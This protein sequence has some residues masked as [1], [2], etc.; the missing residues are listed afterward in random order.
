MDKYRTSRWTYRSYRRTVY[1]HWPNGTYRSK[2]CR[3]LRRNWRNRRIRSNGSYR[4]GHYGRNWGIWRNRRIRPN[5]TYRSNGSSLYNSRRN[6]RVW[7]NR[8]N[9]TH[10]THR[11]KR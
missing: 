10:R 4:Y 6:R 11:T 3:N 5:G 8:T 7:F 2:R 9:R 1:S